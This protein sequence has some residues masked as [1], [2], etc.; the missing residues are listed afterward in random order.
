MRPYVICYTS[1]TVHPNNYIMC[2]ERLFFK[3]VNLEA[4]RAGVKPHQLG[5]WIHRK[6]GDVIIERMCGTGELGTSIPC[7]F[8]RK[9]LDRWAIQWRA[10]SGSQWHRSTDIDVPVSRPTHRQKQL[11]F[12]SLIKV[13]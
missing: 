1:R 9:T 2:A 6:Y 10:H 4:N 8:C 13:N 7:V 5:N 3:H 12:Q 11:I